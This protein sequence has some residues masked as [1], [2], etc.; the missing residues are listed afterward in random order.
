MTDI[1]MPVMNGEQFL[2]SL[3]KDDLLRTVPV[4]VIST[5]ATIGRVSLMLELGAKGYVKKP[6]QPEGLR[7]EIE[8]VLGVSG[9]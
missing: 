2:R 4:V 7:A 8:R 1:N 9:V 3:K 6:F 5:D